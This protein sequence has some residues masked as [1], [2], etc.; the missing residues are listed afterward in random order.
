METHVHG[1]EDSDSEQH[2]LSP[3]WNSSKTQQAF[4]FFFGRYRLVYSR[5]YMKRPRIVQSILKR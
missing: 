4:F 2:Q 3:N 1:L 5:I